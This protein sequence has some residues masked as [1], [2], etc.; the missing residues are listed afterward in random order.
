MREPQ[1]IGLAA[2]AEGN[3][4]FGIVRTGGGKSVIGLVPAAARWATSDEAQLPPLILLVVPL[5]ALGQMQSAAAQAVLD[6]S[7]SELRGERRPSAL[8]VQREQPGARPAA[9]SAIAAG[10]GPTKLPCGICVG[11][12]GELDKRRAQKSDGS[13]CCWKCR[14]SSPHAPVEWCTWCA[15]SQADGDRCGGCHRRKEL[16]ARQKP[17]ADGLA[18]AAGARAR[19]SG[20][21]SLPLPATQAAAAAAAPAPAARLRLSDLPR[22]APERRITEDRDLAIVVVTSSALTAESELAQLLLAASPSAASGSS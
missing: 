21:P 16:L 12:R 9:P 6:K 10:S 7:P 20:K 19:R 4:L 15:S 3:D 8:F 5:V 22:T 2:V 13:S 14:V 18:A 1:R 17:A 11:C